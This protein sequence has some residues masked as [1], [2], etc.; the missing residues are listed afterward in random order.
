MINDFSE[1]YNDFKI[2]RDFNFTPSIEI[3]LH[4]NRPEV[5]KKLKE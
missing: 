4:E 2:G 5:I 1:E 3:R